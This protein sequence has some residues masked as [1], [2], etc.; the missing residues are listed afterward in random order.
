[1]KTVTKEYKVY[2]FNELSETAKA[3]AI[4]WLREC[5]QDDDYWSS[6]IIEDWTTKLSKM[7]FIEPKIA[8]SGFWSQGDGASF[9]CKYIDFEKLIKAF[10]L[11]E[12]ETVLKAAKMDLVGGCIKRIAHHY[13]H[14]YTVKF[15]TESRGDFGN[16]TTQARFETELNDFD[17]SMQESIVTLSK[18]LYRELEN[19]YADY[20]SDRY[21]I[22]NILANDYEFTE[23]GKVFRD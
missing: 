20:N 4:E 23:D 15:E 21:I 8:Y 16:A 22:E 3:R 1:M 5:Q 7:G 19:S 6:G 17:A 11:V 9:T 10:N 12:F 14:P 2:G 18:E 13:F